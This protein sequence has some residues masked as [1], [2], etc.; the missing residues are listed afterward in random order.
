MNTRE[1]PPQLWQGEGKRVNLDR[2][3]LCSS[4]RGLPA[5]RTSYP[6]P[7]LLRLRRPLTDL[8]RGKGPAQ[9]PPQLSC[10]S[11]GKGDPRNTV[12]STVQRHWKIDRTSKG[13]VP[14]QLITLQTTYHSSSFNQELHRAVIKTK[15]NTKLQGLEVG[16][17]LEDTEQASEPKKLQLWSQGLKTSMI[18]TLRALMDKADSMQEQTG[19]VSKKQKS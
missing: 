2:G 3:G 8:G 1:K 13:Y 12:K 11:K 9:P 16:K 6:E 7:N 14:P 4:E 19:N 15:L 18:N 10:P 17:Q 5:G